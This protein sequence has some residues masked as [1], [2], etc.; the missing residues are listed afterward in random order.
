[1]LELYV[2]LGDAK[3]L[4]NDTYSLFSSRQYVGRGHRFSHTVEKA[5]SPWY[6]YSSKLKTAMD[7]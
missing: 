2:L 4:K 7:H 5:I 3:D 1:M 6:H